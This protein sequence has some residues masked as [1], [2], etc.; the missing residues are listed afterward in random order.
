MILE[1]DLRNPAYTL[2]KPAIADEDEDEGARVIP[3][4]EFMS[5]DIFQINCQGVGTGVEV[6]HVAD[7]M[8]REI[9][10]AFLARRD[11]VFS[12]MPL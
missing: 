5:F 11:F 9:S 3:Y 4:L 1:D 12:A 6:I 8:G 7:A 10:M 2:V